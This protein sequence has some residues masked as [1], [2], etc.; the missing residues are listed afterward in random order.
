MLFSERRRARRLLLAV[1]VLVGNRE[2]R[3]VAAGPRR[4]KAWVPGG[5]YAKVTELW[6]AGTRWRIR[7]DEWRGVTH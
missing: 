3:R 2:D 5:L 7:L 6:P 1:P 4:S